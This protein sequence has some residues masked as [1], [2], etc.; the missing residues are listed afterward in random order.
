MTKK[1]TEFC[2]CQEAMDLVIAKDEPFE[3]AA[4]EVIKD[5]V[6]IFCYMCSKMPENKEKLF[7]EHL[8]KQLEKDFFNV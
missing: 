3:E 5:M 1:N 4:A 8:K 2:I 6:N 7:K